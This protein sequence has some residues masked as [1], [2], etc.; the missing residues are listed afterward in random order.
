MEPHWTTIGIFWV[1]VLVCAATIGATAV[2]MI[3]YRSQTDPE[4]I[5]YTKHDPKRPTIISLVIENI[6]RGVAHD[7][8][9]Y[10]SEKIPYGAFGWEAI[11]ADKI[12]WMTYGPLCSGIPSLPPGGRREMDW[13]QYAGLRSIISDRSI[14][15][16]AT[17]KAKCRFSYDLMTISTYST[18]DIASYE[19]TVAHMD[20]EP[21]KIR[22]EL[23]KIGKALGAL[24]SRSHP[25]AVTLTNKIESA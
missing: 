13:G 18:I 5:V 21:Q 20:N 11:S 25:L 4:V 24:G 10:S 17:F 19:N 8:R 23:A 14:S 12:E 15:V 9:F 6:G 2:N 16:R 1:T 7:I 22:E 3:L